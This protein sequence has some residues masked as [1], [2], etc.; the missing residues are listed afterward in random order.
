MHVL[1]MV[2]PRKQM[3]QN[4]VIS[5]K[6]EISEESEHFPPQIKITPKCS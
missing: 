4:K 6:Q 5:T 1:D 3:L 2:E